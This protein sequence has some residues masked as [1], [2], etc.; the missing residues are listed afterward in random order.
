MSGSNRISRRD[1]I[2]GTTAAIG[3]FI[4]V[5]IGIPAVAY[6]LDPATKSG[7]KQSSVVVG[8]LEDIPVGTPYPFSFTITKVN[9]WE[10][11]SRPARSSVLRP[12]WVAKL[13]L[14]NSWVSMNSQNR[15]SQQ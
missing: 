9:G 13:V 2:K 7:G 14:V 10:R 11:T 1:F 6:L 15:C 3:G 4:A 8:K 5:A 12:S